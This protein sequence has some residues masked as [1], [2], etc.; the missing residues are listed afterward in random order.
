MPS[1]KHGTTL[2][3][4]MDAMLKNNYAFSKD[5]EKYCYIFMHP[6]CTQYEIKQEDPLF[7]NPRT[8]NILSVSAPVKVKL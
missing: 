2:L 6:A 8:F 1:F 7:S 4:N 5:V 3:T